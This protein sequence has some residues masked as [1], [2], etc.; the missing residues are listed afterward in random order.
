L[1]YSPNDKTFDVW[2]QGIN[3]NLF[4]P[5]FH[6]R[7]HV[8]VALWMRLLRN[9]NLIF[10]K[11]FDAGLWGLGPEILN[12]DKI[13][14]QASFDALDKKELVFQ[15]YAIKE[16]LDLFEKIFKF[17]SKS[18]IA[19]NF[20]WDLSLNEALFENG[21]RFLQGMKYQKLPYFY[22]SKRKMIYHYTGQKNQFGQTYLVRNCSFEPTLFKNQD[23]VSACLKDI[24]KAFFWKKP[25]IITTH[26]LNYIGSIVENNRKANLNSLNKL[27]SEIITMW[28]NVEF[29]TT[30]ELGEIINH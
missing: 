22:G 15:Q 16:G 29:L 30:V 9:N 2:K 4:Y 8:N 18:Y 13:N 10:R 19:N 6:G 7:E 14:I 3:E 11:A 23:N 26:R 5:Q 17:R 25:A 20:V 21:I 1:K 27:L 24:S 12:V 28:P